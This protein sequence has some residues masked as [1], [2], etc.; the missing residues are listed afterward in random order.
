[1]YGIAGRLPPS[2][3]VRVTEGGGGAEKGKSGSVPESSGVH[4]K[5][6]KG[7]GEADVHVFGYVGGAS[8]VG[9]A[10]GGGDVV[11]N[12]D[13]QRGVGGRGDAPT[14][15]GAVKERF[16]QQEEGAHNVLNNVVDDSS[17]G[18]AAGKE[19]GGGV[20]REAAAIDA[21]YVAPVNVVI[22]TMT[23]RG[24]NQ[25]IRELMKVEAKP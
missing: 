14:D 12:G 18:S 20:D 3:D 10:G 22:A 16:A 7:V 1:M 17:G 23:Q 15:Q 2:T 11:Q 9:E 21:G 24:E 25:A 5:G 8:G 19:A 4:A 6:G 13:D